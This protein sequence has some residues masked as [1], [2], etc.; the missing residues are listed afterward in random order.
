M[1]KGEAIRYG[2][3]AGKTLAAAESLTGGMIASDVCAVPGASSIFQGGFVTYQDEVKEQILG[4]SSDVITKRSAVSAACARQMAAGAREK[5]HTDYALSATGYAG[6]TGDN[7][8]LVFIGLAS[9]N[10]TAVRRLRLS[11]SRTAI[12]QMT[13]NLALWTWIQAI[14]NNEE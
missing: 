14:K 4:V 10:R 2:I 7:V 11:G 1:N 5:L 13:A 3:R 6:P 8:G 9:Q 12:R